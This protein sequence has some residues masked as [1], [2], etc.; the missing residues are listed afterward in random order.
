MTP[1]PV[2][3]FLELV[4]VLEKGI[5]LEGV[6]ARREL[7]GSRRT[8]AKRMLNAA[9]H[10]VIGAVSDDPREPGTAALAVLSINRLG[11]R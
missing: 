10:K 11:R 5:V 7:D 9:G 8:F 2:S 4:V 6:V 1:P 3:P